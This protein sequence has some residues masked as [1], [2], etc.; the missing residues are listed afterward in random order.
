MPGDPRRHDRRP[1]DPGRHL[2]RRPRGRR[3]DQPETWAKANPNLGVSVKLEYLAAECKRGAGAA[4]PRERLQALP[5]QPCGPSRRSAG[6]RSIA[7]TTRAR[8]GWDQCKGPLGW[9]ELEAQ[10]L[11]QRRNAFLGLD[12]ASTIDLTALVWLFPP[13][14]PGEKIKVLPRFFL[15]AD[16]VKE[17]EKRDR[18]PYRKLAEQGAVVLTPGNVTDYAFVKDRIFREAE[19]WRLIKGAVDRFNATQIVVEMIQEGLPLELFGQGFVSMSAPA[20]EL[21]RLVIAGELEH[22]GHPILREH[23]KAV[24]VEQDP[25]GNIKPTKAKSSGHVDGIVSLVEALGVAATAETPKE[26][27]Y[28]R[29]GVRTV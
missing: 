18:L 19:I 20:K 3:L 1:R 29:R 8:F 4:A 6:C 24:A 28:E 23:A 25:A 2:R 21:E 13:A 14:T 9:R 27:V 26:S 7:S 16:R 5:P 22:G 10:L 17:A 11:G 12:L 15:P